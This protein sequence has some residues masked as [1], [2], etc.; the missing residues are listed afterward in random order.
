MYVYVAYLL[1]CFDEEDN[2]DVDEVE[3]KLG[4]LMM[5]RRYKWHFT[6][7]PDSLFSFSHFVKGN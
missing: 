5:M 3:A 2:N 7:F 6:P 1:F 4:Q